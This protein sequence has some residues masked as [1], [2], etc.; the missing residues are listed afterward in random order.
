MTLHTCFRYQLSAALGRFFLLPRPGWPPAVRTLFGCQGASVPPD[1]LWGQKKRHTAGRPHRLGGIPR[2]FIWTTFAVPRFFMIPVHYTMTGE[3]CQHP[4]NARIS[5]YKTRSA[6]VVNL[7]Q[8]G[9]ASRIRACKWPLRGFA[10][11]GREKSEWQI[12]FY[13]SGLILHPLSYLFLSLSETLQAF[14]VASHE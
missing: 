1:C 10:R 3:I 11:Q 7:Y 8:K 2:S 9:T 6:Q 5:P 12:F 4:L 13:V 14:R